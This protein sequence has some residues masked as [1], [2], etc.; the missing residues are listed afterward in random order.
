MKSLRVLI[1]LVFAAGSFGCTSAGPRNVALEQWSPDHGYR[2]E[3]IQKRHPMGRVALL[4]AFSGG[5][6][7]A[8]A[9]AYGV[10]QE[11]RNVELA[12]GGRLIDEIDLITSV[13][14]GSFTSAYYGLFGDRI[15]EDY[16]ERVLRRN[17]TRSFMAQ[18]LNPLNW[19]RMLTGLSRTELAINI[20]HREIFDEATFADLLERP[21]PFLR[22]NATDLSITE[23][24]TFDQPNFDLI[25][26]DLSKLEVAR[27]VAASSAVP[28]AFS[29]ITFRNYAGH[30]GYEL[31]EDI[32]ESLAGDD[33][34]PR[35]RALAEIRD[36]Y[37]DSSKRRYI[38]L[39]D[40]G[41][42]DNVGLRAILND[43]TLAGGVTGRIKEFRAKRPTDIVVV[44]V[45]AQVN[46]K[47]DF[48]LSAASPGLGPL[49]SAITG[50]PYNRFTFETV[51][52]TRRSIEGWASEINRDG[53][54]ARVRTHLINVSFAASHDPEEREY[55]NALPTSMNLKD[56]Q[57]DRLIEFGRRAFRES[58]DTKQ[59]VRDLGAKIE[60]SPR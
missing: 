31:S 26:S 25:C 4:L 5:G 7:R 1:V 24:F 11:L 35:R 30:C 19:F 29:P 15:F 45:D 6:T 13:S 57:V 8:S 33:I 42:A 21:S 60:E 56:E 27:A 59:L 22:I 37:L 10:L 9:L 14:G 36:S 20:Y 46:P 2:L 54:S 58:P 51:E 17:F 34:S 48:D 28:V 53:L 44:V 41:V 32:R 38:H 23:Q 43:V 52:L 18:L 16:E 49:I 12:G 40:G 3:Q 50:S 39:V 55:F 47:R